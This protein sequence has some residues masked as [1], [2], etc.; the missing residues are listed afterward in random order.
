[1]DGHYI[2][3]IPPGEIDRHWFLVEHKLGNAIAY[4]DNKYSLS[5][6]Y[7]AIK[8]EEMQLWLIKSA[9]D[10]Q[11]VVV[12]QIVDYPE[13]RVCLIMFTGGDKIDTY[14]HLISDISRFAR[15]NR[16]KSIEFY[17]R[18]GWLKKISVLGFDHIH[19]VF[20]LELKE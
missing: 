13:K 14:K 18:H 8:N 19:S 20:R 7:E 2:Y 16:C 9:Y 4:S 11:A 17:G 1:M 10:L 3:A 6:V 15:Y 5:S 12:T